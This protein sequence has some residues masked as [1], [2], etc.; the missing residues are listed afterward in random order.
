MRFWRLHYSVHSVI[1]EGK[2]RYLKVNEITQKSL[3]LLWSIIATLLTVAT[4]V[5]TV[6]YINQHLYNLTL[7]DVFYT[8]VMSSTSGLSTDIVPDNIFSRTV[9]LSLMIV[10]AIYIPT[11]L[12]NLLNLANSRSQYLHAYKK[13]SAHVIL[14]GNFEITSLRGFLR[15]FDRGF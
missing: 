3:A 8:I 13:D 14:A 7:F 5:H 12:A 6:L 10:G 15:G 9:T 2:V 1:G 4:Y 11:N